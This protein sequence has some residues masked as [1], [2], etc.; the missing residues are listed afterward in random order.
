MTG[1]LFAT[2]KNL[3][4][5]HSGP[6]T[7]DLAVA[8]PLLSRVLLVLGL[9][10]A[11][12]AIGVSAR[13]A[14]TQLL[15]GVTYET[16]V[17]FTAH[18]PVALHIVRG[19]RPVGLYRLRPVL[20]NETVRR[21]ETVSSMQ[22]RLAAGA[23]TVGVN[24]DFFSSKQG[25]PS[26]ILLRDGVL[27]SAPSSNRSSTGIT[28]DGTLDVRKVKLFGTWR[29]LGQRRAVNSLN[30]PP[31]ANGMASL[32]RRLGRE[33]ARDPGGARSGPLPVSRHD[34]ERGS[35]RD[36]VRLQPERLGAHRSG[37]GGARR[38]WY[39]RRRSSPPK[40]RSVRR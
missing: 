1:G 18:G 31:A 20:S 35:H 12:L 9:A 17:E 34:A 25:G 32:H 15:P 3:Q 28:L 5:V 19:P 24:G 33:D 23:T 40:R 8:R 39:R 14:T 37:D 13:A 36:R 26:G 6:G 22:R 27:V 29:G 38:P 2:C 21:R 30:E 11:A 16:G 4:I 7:L 10:A